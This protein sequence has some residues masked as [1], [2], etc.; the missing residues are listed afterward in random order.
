MCNAWT[1]T[2]QDWSTVLLILG[3]TTWTC[4]SLAALKTSVGADISSR[5][6]IHAGGKARVKEDHIDVQEIIQG[7]ILEWLMA[8][9]GYGGNVLCNERHHHPSYPPGHCTSLQT[10]DR[11]AMVVALVW[12]VTFLCICASLIVNNIIIVVV[13][14]HFHPFAFSTIYLLCHSSSSQD[15][16]DSVT[17]QG[18][19]LIRTIALLVVRSVLFGTILIANS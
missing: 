11:G 7:D 5:H 4:H 8:R 2:I 9:L 17:Y 15:S 1:A 18:P 16:T 14:C 12:S 19:C 13:C 10:G 3:S 6:V